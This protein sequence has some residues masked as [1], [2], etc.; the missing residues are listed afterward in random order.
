MGLFNEL[1]ELS[2]N[3]KDLVIKDESNS[4]DVKTSRSQDFGTSASLEVDSEAPNDARKPLSED[5][6]TDL[7]SEPSDEVENDLLTKGFQA[8][9]P[10]T[11]KQWRKKLDDKTGSNSSLRIPKDEKRPVEDMLTD[12]ERRYGYSISMNDLARLGL[13]LLTNDFKR[14]R[15]RALVLEILKDE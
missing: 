6:D 8:V 3:Q 13:M 12:L 9:D 7:P 5:V 14:K 11:A 4:G 2:K 1:N 15:S 10:L